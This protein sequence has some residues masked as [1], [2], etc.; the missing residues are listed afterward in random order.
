MVLT[1]AS[2]NSRPIVLTPSSSSSRQ[3]WPG[4]VEAHNPSMFRKNQ[5]NRNRGMSS[6]GGA[7]A[8]AYI[9]PRSAERQSESSA[10]SRSAKRMSGNATVLATPKNTRSDAIGDWRQHL[11]LLFGR[12]LRG[13][14]KALRHLARRAE[15]IAPV[16]RASEFGEFPGSEGSEGIILVGRDRVLIA[17]DDLIRSPVASKKVGQ[18]RDAVWVLRIK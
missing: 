14:Q 17:V 10:K 1:R 4:R 13:R 5:C 11:T 2:R 9:N 7:R 8:R 18:E 3:P 6:L 12:G 15:Y 16:E